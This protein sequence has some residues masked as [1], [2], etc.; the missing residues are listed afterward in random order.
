M[1]GGSQRPKVATRA[2]LRRVRFVRAQFRSNNS[3]CE[4]FPDESFTSLSPDKAA[5]SPL[6][7]DEPGANSQFPCLGHLTCLGFGNGT[8]QGY[9]GSGAQTANTPNVRNLYPGSYPLIQSLTVQAPSRSIVWEGV[10]VDGIGNGVRIFRFT[11]VRVSTLN[12]DST[13]ILG[14]I[15]STSANI[16]I[17]INN[18]TNLNLGRWNR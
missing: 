10:P 18:G 5:A 14:T 4:S 8:G 15:T 7:L 9:Y 2:M 13:A 11:G 1:N 12:S 17:V 16:P 6:I 3:T